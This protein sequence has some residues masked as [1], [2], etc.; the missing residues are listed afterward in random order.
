MV[1]SRRTAPAVGDGLGG[2]LA[3]D[4]HEHRIL[5]RWIERRR[6]DEVS[7]DRDAFPSVHFE[8]LDRRIEQ[9]RDL[10]FGSGAVASRSNDF[11]IWQGHELA[12]T[13]IVEAGEAVKGEL[14]VRRDVVR[15]GAGKRLRGHANRIGRTVERRPI[16]V[17][18]RRVLR[19]RDEVQ[20]AALLVDAGDPGGVHAASRDERL[21]AVP[22]HAVDVHP[23]IL[24]GDDEELS[25]VADGPRL[26]KAAKSDG[27][28]RFVAITPHLTR[29][30]G[31]RVGQQ[32]GV[33]VLQAIELLDEDACRRQPIASV[34]CSARAD[35][36]GSAA[37]SPRHR[38]CRPRRRAPPS[39]S[40]PASGYGTLIVT[41]YGP[42]F[43]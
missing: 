24:L 25:A 9:R 21:A 15:V 34:R 10:R 3:V 17:A 8:E 5:L 40:S 4:V 37:T 27:D 19:R 42:V 11:V 31:A 29:P 36:R 7:V 12:Q 30:A 28:E 1:E 43:G 39:S 35:R 41:G 14:A 33:G 26:R 38:R 13:W 2:R 20:P 18:L 16:Q 23:A 22:R 32:V 6:L